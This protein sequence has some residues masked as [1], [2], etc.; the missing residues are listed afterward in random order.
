MKKTIKEELINYL[1]KNRRR[2]VSRK[3]LEDKRDI[4]KCLASSVS[5]K[6]RDLYSKHP[7]IDR[8]IGKDGLAEYK[9]II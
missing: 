4:F 3:E 7:N 1:F 9:Y 2:W 5:R 6:S 8:R